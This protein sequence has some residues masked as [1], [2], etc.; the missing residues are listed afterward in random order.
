MFLQTNRGSG[1]TNAFEIDENGDIKVTNG[2]FEIEGGGITF[3]TNE[4]TL[5]SGSSSNM[6]GIQGGATYM[7]GRI[8]LRGGQSGQSGDIRFFAQGAT[9]TQ[10]ERARIASN[11][12]INIGSRTTTPDELVHI[13]TSS[14]QANIHVEGATDGQIILRAHSGDSVIHF[15]DA[16]ATSVGKI[17]YDHGTD[18]LAFNTN[19][20]ERMK[21][22]SSG[23]LLPNANNTHDLGSTSLRWRN[24]Y[25]TDLQLS[26]EGKTNDVDGTWGDYTIQ[27][28]ESELFLINN[29]NGKKYQFM[30]KEVN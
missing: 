15:G 6:L 29:R 9:A 16:S 18:S 10:A 27:E 12:R 3:L 4:S 20:N 2:Q 8:E 26:N 7:G 28:G 23:H 11:G 17:A 25:T 13:H 19:S 24:V 14:G 5:Q 21:I 1:L 30:L 22:D